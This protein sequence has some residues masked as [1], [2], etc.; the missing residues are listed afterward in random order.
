[1]SGADFAWI[2]VAILRLTIPSLFQA[3]GSLVLPFFLARFR[4]SPTTESLEQAKHLRNLSYVSV[5]FWLIS[6]ARY[7]FKSPSILHVYL[8]LRVVRL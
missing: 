4:S 1:M 3:L 5:L 7:V 6:I 8:S 2:S